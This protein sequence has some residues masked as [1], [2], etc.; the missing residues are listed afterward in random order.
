LPL[1]T[2][3]LTAAEV[4]TYRDYAFDVYFRNPH[5]LSK[6]GRAFG[7]EALHHVKEM[8][9]HKLDRKYRQF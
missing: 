7:R 6:I 8:T 9:R 4:L 1:P 5:Y 2:N 3:H